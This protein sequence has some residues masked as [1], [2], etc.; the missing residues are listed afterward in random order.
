[1]TRVR[2][3]AS[4]SV[5]GAAQY[6]IRLWVRPDRLAQ[7]GITVPEI[8]NAI[9]QQN[10]VNPAGTIGGEPIPKGQEFTYAVRAQGRLETPEQFGE[11]VLR[12][13]PGGAIVRV[14][15]VARIELGAQNY[16][17]MARLNGRSCALIA[18]YQLPNSNAVEAADGAK[19]LMAQLKQ[20]FPPDLDYVVS[21]DTT[22][23]VTEGM[24]EI[25]THPLRGHRAGHHRGVHLPA[26]LAGDAD[27]AAGRAGV[28]G[29]HV[30]ALSA[31]RLLHQHALAVRPGARHRVGGGRRHRGGRDRRTPHRARAFA[32]GGGAQRH[33]GSQRTGRCHRHHPGGGV[34]SDRL[35]PRHHRP[36][37]PAVR[38]DH[39]GVG[40]HLRLQRAHAF[41]GPGGAAAAAQ[42]EELAG[43]CRS[44]STGSTSGLAAP[45]TATW[46]SAAS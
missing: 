39:R 43:R 6:A 24:K 2:G 10:T 40:H 12:A 22:L 33:A 8:I 17:R 14:K 37:L 35:H 42:E 18:L 32:Q 25:Q 45:P 15:D 11:I 9:Q 1:M 34:P 44:S 28:A 19:K 38:G 26:R 23:A 4:V 3:I 27:S 20:S 13:A 5:F 46:A 21:L 29:R 41:A 16:D 36:A 30:R 31:V 7:M